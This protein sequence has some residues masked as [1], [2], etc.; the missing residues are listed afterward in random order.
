METKNRLEGLEKLEQELYEIQG[1]PV[2]EQ[3]NRLNKW[4]QKNKIILPSG[5]SS[6]R[7][8][9]TFH[10]TQAAHSFLQS[11][12]M[13]NACVSAEESSGLA[14]QAC[15]SAKWSCRWAAIAAIVACISIVVMLCL[16]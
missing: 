8:R 2:D 6:T 11:K 5:G 13:L 7:Q 3:P 15:N 4:G 10:M 12:M 14:K 1:L 16:K 9:Q